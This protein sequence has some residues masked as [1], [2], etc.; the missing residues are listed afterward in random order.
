MNM[1]RRSWLTIATAAATFAFIVTA[2]MLA[3]YAQP[4]GENPFDSNEWQALKSDL[5][6][7]PDDTVAGERARTLD[8][9]L[10]QTFFRRRERIRTGG[11]LLLV[12]LVVFLVAIKRANRRSLPEPDAPAPPSSVTVT[13]TAY[14]PLSA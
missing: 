8:L 7:N 3:S 14:V 5:S 6:E 10:R 9:E 11:T 13:F 2:L 1:P 12:A 4:V